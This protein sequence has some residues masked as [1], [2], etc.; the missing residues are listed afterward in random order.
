[1]AHYA[2]IGVCYAAFLENEKNVDEYTKNRALEQLRTTSYIFER[3]MGPVTDEQ[4]ACASHGVSIP[5]RV[6]R[7]Y[8]N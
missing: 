6:E 4:D 5:I 7:K 2:G 1:M 3:L 8:R